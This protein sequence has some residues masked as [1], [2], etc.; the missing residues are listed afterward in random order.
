[1]VLMLLGADVKGSKESVGGRR[2]DEFQWMSLAWL[3]TGSATSGDVQKPNFGSVSVL[4]T[5][6]EPKPKGL[7]RN[8]GFRGFFKTEFVSYK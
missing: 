4:K 3:V 2:K 5:G 1:M 6:T 8:F 7:T